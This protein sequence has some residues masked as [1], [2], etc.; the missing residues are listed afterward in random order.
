LI[1]GLKRNETKPLALPQLTLSKNLC[2][3]SITHYPIYAKVDFEQKVLRRPHY[4]R[5][6]VVQHQFDQLCQ[7]I[8]TAQIQSRLPGVLRYLLSV[9]FVREFFC[10][11]IFD[12]ADWFLVW[13]SFP[14]KLFRLILF[15]SCCRS[16]EWFLNRKAKNGVIKIGAG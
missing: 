13:Q 8:R 5:T 10:A 1:L 11:L 6:Q 2:V 16:I 4:P 14:F 15:I 7:F 3:D 12:A 9:I